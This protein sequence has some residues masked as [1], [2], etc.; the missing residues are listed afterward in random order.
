MTTPTYSDVTLQALQD[1]GNDPAKL[2]GAWHNA[3]VELEK[4]K[5][6][7]SFLRRAAFEIYIPNPAEGTN[8][9]D[10]GG[11]WQLRAVHKINYTF[12]K[13]QHKTKADAVDAAQTR[14]AA[15][16]PEG[17]FIADRLIKWEPEL[18]IKEYRELKPEYRTIIDALV[19]TRPGMPELEI[20]P[21]KAT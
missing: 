21:P 10:L 12:D 15:L 18:S 4:I 2:L 14:M 13:G 1:F 3:A 6:R 8:R 5:A 17:A 16:G 19:V 20:E 7:E 9:A 11:G